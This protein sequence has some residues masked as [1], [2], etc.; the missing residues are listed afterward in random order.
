MIYPKETAWFQELDT[1][2]NVKP[3]TESDFYNEDYIGLKKLNDDGNLTFISLPG[4]HLQ[5]ST[6]DV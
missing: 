1:K 5:F 4:D 6:E 3:L 2:G